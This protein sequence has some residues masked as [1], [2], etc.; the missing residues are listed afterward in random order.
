MKT[1]TLEAGQ[2][3][4]VRIPLKPRNPFFFFFRAFSQLL[5]LRFTAMVT[6]SFHMYSRSSHHFNKFPA[7]KWRLYLTKRIPTV[8][9]SVALSKRN[10]FL[11]IYCKLK[12]NFI[13]KSQLL[14]R[15]VRLRESVSK[16][17]IQ[18]QFSIVRVRLRESVRLQEYVNTEFDWEVKQGFE[19][20]SVS[21][22]VR[23][24]ECPLAL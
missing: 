1:H 20:A 11:F 14:Y 9:L 18:F 10:I 13:A 2:S 19:K 17:K 4:R 16:R 24:Q 22:A 12:T 23:L 8:L 3:I 15:G 5:K 6:Y 7:D 21:R